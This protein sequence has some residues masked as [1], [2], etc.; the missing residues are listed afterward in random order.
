MR[1]SMRM[2]WSLGLLFGIPCAVRAHG[3]AGR[4]VCK[5]GLR[6]LWATGFLLSLEFWEERAALSTRTARA[7]ITQKLYSSP[8][9][10][11]QG[12][13]TNRKTQPLKSLPSATVGLS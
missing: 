2:I 12:Y 7:F 5:G 13:R 1:D 3:P 4:L 10:K 6:P 11:L 9:R 8:C